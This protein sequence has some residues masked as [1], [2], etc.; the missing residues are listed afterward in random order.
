MAFLNKK[1]EKYNKKNP[2]SMKNSKNIEKP[3]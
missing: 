1:K 3:K 2:P